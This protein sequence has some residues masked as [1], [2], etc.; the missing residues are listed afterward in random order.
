MITRGSRYVDAAALKVQR[1][2]GDYS[3][4]VYPSREIVPQVVD[5]RLR[6]IVGGERLDS[7]AFEYYGNP[8]LWWVL[9]RANPEVIFPDDI[10][11]GTQLRIPGVATV[12]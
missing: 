4:A 6:T 10:P 8:W 12:R 1:A 2:D 11:V 5:Y 3:I 9:A 7:L